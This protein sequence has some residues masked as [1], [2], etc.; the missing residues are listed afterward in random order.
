MKT[1]TAENKNPFPG[2]RPFREDEQYL[3]F[4]RE[5]QV[6]A[7]VDKLAATHFLAV[8]GTSGSGKSSLVNCGLRPSLHG[9][10]MARAG[11]SWRMAQFRP[12]ND[13]MRAL[14][15]A[16]AKDGVL[17]KGYQAA[18]LTLAEIVDTTLRMSKLGLIDIY[19][20]ANLGEDVNLLVVVD[21]FEELF[22]YRQP[23]GQQQNVT[24]P[25]E[26][27]T[28]FVNLLLAAKEQ[29]THPIYIVLTM[30]SDFLGDC[31][32]FS[33][34]AEAIN[35]GQYLVPRMTRDERRAAI[36]GPVGVGG[37]EISPVLL[38]RL[39]NDVGDNPDQLSI[40]QHALNRTWSKW[41]GSGDT[42]PLDL[43]HYE[44]IGTM[45]RALDQHAEKAYAELTTA[46]QR[47]I[48]EKL[49]KALTDKATD[50]RGVRRPTRLDTLCALAEATP[51]EITQ[52]ID[53][54]RKPSR[55]FLMP[56]ADETLDA[57][58][59][60]DISHESL[61]RVWERL[62]SWADQEAQSAH[63][64]C[65]LAETAVLHA[66]G[67]AGLWDDPDLQ[68]AV[69]WQENIR[70]NK[71]W[72]QQYDPGF[73]GAMAFLQKSKE[74]RDTEV[75]EIEFNH[76][77]RTVRN[78]LIVVVLILL[79]WDP[80]H[81]T[82]PAPVT[83]RVTDEVREKLKEANILALP[84]G[85]T[86]E[87]TGE[88]EGYFEGFR[89]NEIEA[90]DKALA[91]V[92]DQEQI[93]AALR[94]SLARI[95]EVEVHSSGNEPLPAKSRTYTTWVA[96][97]SPAGQRKNVELLKKAGL[98]IVPTAQFL[99]SD[100]TERLFVVPDSVKVAASNQTGL[101][102]LALKTRWRA[103][104]LKRPQG[105]AL[106][107]ETFRLLFHLFLYLGLVFAV[108]GIYRTFLFGAIGGAGQQGLAATPAGI[109]WRR[110]QDRVYRF[111]DRFQSP[112]SRFVVS[113]SLLLAGLILFGIG[114]FSFVRSPA[115]VLRHGV[116]IGLILILLVPTEAILNGFWAPRLKIAQGTLLKVCGLYALAGLFLLF[117]STDDWVPSVLLSQKRSVL[118]LAGIGLLVLG[119]R[120]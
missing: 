7:M 83:Y 36:S 113:V 18:G 84:E 77:M 75:A 88:G 23:A 95:L 63:M 100:R 85:I 21:Q 22:R 54:F 25:I 87:L 70:P 15:R 110:F 82:P 117:Y 33:G 1:V 105:L 73:D 51:D 116:P 86:N 13:P 119:M 29:T 14:A 89:P 27:A 102:A 58:T 44:L 98:A 97:W 34:L 71:E 112:R 72:A 93:A 16:L 4:G 19:E 65:R 17:F 43:P 49:F 64:Y 118:A 62:K 90:V 115:S 52:V 114:W 31:T 30:R 74:A 76:K 79:L 35:A 111:H 109:R 56:P 61:M 20:Q 78:V 9:G 81:L 2:L 32:Q 42:G 92:P 50:P 99:N 8:V 68:G 107:A 55:S 3:F 106:V 28:A 120:K 26:E 66:K 10:L 11:T 40:L 53:V 46:R 41:E 101:I 104:L 47:Q 24:S 48:C 69:D 38:T 60:I 39:I 6:D 12:G 80:L 96:P 5:N 45:T 108:G 94:G 103:S 67:K 37:A 91:G 59:V 57:K